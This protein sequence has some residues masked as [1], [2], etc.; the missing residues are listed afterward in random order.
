M[1]SF[2]TVPILAALTNFYRVSVLQWVSI[3]QWISTLQGFFQTLIGLHNLWF[4]ALLK[5]TLDFLVGIGIEGLFEPMRRLLRVPRRDFPLINLIRIA[6]AWSLPLV[7]DR[8]ALGFLGFVVAITLL[9]WY[10]LNTPGFGVGYSFS[11]PFLGA[12]RGGNRLAL[13]LLLF[14]GLVLYLVWLAFITLV[15]IDRVIPDIFVRA[16]LSRLRTRIGFNLIVSMNLRLVRFLPVV[17]YVLPVAGVGLIFGVNK[18]LERLM[19]GLLLRLGHQDCL[20]LPKQLLVLLHILL[21][22]AGSHALLQ[23]SQVAQVAG[24][25][26]QN[27]LELFLHLG[28]YGLEAF[29]LGHFVIQATTQEQKDHIIKFL[30]LF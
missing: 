11:Y 8:L 1:H 20:L 17:F 4:L 16:S 2:L 14:R 27:N 3:F 13:I 22:I 10:V 19:V 9:V 12:T 30:F 23:S 24:S 26:V 18:F 7:L 28:V 15:N 21:F 25:L 29:W 6:L 5:E